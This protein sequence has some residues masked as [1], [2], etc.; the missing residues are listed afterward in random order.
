M[1][2]CEIRCMGAA[3]E[4]LDFDNPLKTLAL[5]PEAKANEMA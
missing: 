5:I 2:F 3:E 1:P 4:W